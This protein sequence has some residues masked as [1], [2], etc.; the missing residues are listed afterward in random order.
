MDTPQIVEVKGGTSIR[1]NPSLGSMGFVPKPPKE[2]PVETDSHQAHEPPP[3]A[4][5]P[6]AQQPAEAPKAPEPIVEPVKAKTPAEKIAEKLATKE[7]PKAEEPKAEPKA[8]DTKPAENPEDKLELSPRA[9]E[10]TKDQF[11][12]LKSVTKQLRDAEAKARAELAE[13]KRQME[14]Q[15]KLVP[16]SQIKEEE[17]KKLM[18]EHRVMSERIAALD[19]KAHPRYKEQYEIPKQGFIKAA[20]ELLAANQV[21]G[22]IAS[23]LNLPRNELG[24]AVAKLTEGLPS[25]DASEVQANIREAYKIAQA[26]QE[27]SSKAAESLKAIHESGA[28]RMVEDF[29]AAF[30]DLAPKVGEFAPEW[31]IDEKLDPETKARAE[32]YNEGLRSLRANAERYAFGASNERTASEIGIKAAAYDHQVKHVMPNL[33]REMEN[34]AREN[35]KLRAENNGIK[36]HNAN[37]GSFVSTSSDSS[38]PDPRKMSAEEAAEYFARR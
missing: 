16:V 2:D 17:Y 31:E 1:D 28:R 13:M 15:S 20:D 38:A 10:A 37:R 5:K 3:A 19:F 18:E 6:V 11:K 24:K 33:V 7:P 22:S 21:E 26:E 23:L 14:E 4:E 35:A 25:F 32:A 36:K 30:A 8:D 34:L 12:T 27:A 29:N 9:S